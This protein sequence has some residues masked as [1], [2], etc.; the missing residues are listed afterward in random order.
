MEV[1][2]KLE[3]DLQEKAAYVL[4]RRFDRL[5]NRRFVLFPLLRYRML[6]RKVRIVMGDK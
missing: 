3:A 6:L 1:L 5:M 2:K 4:L